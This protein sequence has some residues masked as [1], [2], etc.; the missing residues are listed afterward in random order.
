[1]TDKTFSAEVSKE[2]RL[3]GV[4]DVLRVDRVAGWVI[5]RTDPY[6]SAVVEVRCG[7]RLIGTIVANRLRKD[8]EQRA[9]GTGHYGFVYAFDPPLAD[10]MESAVTA[11]AKSQ[12]GVELPL[13][14]A[15]GAARSISVERKMLGRLLSEVTDMRTDIGALRQEMAS[16]T[17]SHAQLLERLELVQLRIEGALTVEAMPSLRP[18]GWLRTM[19]GAGAIIAVGSI[20]VGMFS[21]WAT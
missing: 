20:V 15:A 8:L 9:V 7:D 18:R 1:M 6:Q 13:Q 10:G 12:D 3:Y 14:P 2:A 19:A 16:A 4:I 21:L 11:I 5:D 17:A